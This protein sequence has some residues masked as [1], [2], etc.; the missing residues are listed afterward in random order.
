MAIAPD[1]RMSTVSGIQRSQD[2]REA[3]LSDP[4]GVRLLGLPETSAA[5][6][7]PQWLQVYYVPTQ[8]D[9]S[10]K[11]VKCSIHVQILDSVIQDARCYTPEY[12]HWSM[13]TACATARI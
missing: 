10:S 11:H 12:M 1:P 7:A 8:D 4:S 3:S 6:P 2:R 5:R 9:L 13:S